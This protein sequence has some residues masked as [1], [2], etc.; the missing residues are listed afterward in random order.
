[1]NDKLNSL[2][3]SLNR[4]EYSGDKQ[5]VER[6]EKEIDRLLAIDKRIQDSKASKWEL[7]N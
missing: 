6:I 5:E 3:G 4:A 2:K 1:M 7:N